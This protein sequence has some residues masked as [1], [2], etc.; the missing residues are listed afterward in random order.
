MLS[1]AGGIQYAVIQVG[2][3]DAAAARFMRLGFEHAGFPDPDSRRLAL[4]TAGIELTVSGKAAAGAAGLEGLDALGLSCGLGSCRDTETAAADGTR[5]RLA[6]AVPGVALL[7]CRHAASGR[8]AAALAASAETPRSIAGIT[9]LAKAPRVAARHTAAALGGKRLHAGGTAIVLLGG[10]LLRF[11]SPAQSADIYPNLSH[12]RPCPAVLALH[13]EVRDIGRAWARLAGN[14]VPHC[15]A[16]DGSIRVNPDFAGGMVLSFEP[17]GAG[18]RNLGLCA[19]QGQ[20]PSPKVVI[21][22]RQEA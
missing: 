8:T 6:Q 18:I 4:G 7:A 19:I 9:L 1:A 11:I 12:Q 3:L 22:L 21:P 13:I 15:L 16:A 10:S 14:G 20:A 5:I 2:D 17:P